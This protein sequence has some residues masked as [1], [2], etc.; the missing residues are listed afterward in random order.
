MTYFLS[1]DTKISGK[2]IQHKSRSVDV[3][4][5]SASLSISLSN[6]HRQTDIYMYIC[7]YIYIYVIIIYYSLNVLFRF[8]RYKQNLENGFNVYHGVWV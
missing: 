5:Q 2:W 6:L 1:E 3:I 8:I 7:I 4:D